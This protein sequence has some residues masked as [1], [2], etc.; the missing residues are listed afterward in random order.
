MNILLI[1]DTKAGHYS[2]GI[3]LASELSR[4]LD[5]SIVEININEIHK[6][7]N[8]EGKCIII[9]VGHAS[10]T[11]MIKIKEILSNTNEC[12]TIAVF[13]PSF[14]QDI[15]DLIVAPEHDFINKRIPNNCFLYK[16][17]LSKISNQ[18][19]D[20]SL[21]AI[22]IGGPNTNIVYD[23]AMVIK[24]IEYVLGIFPEKRKIVSNSRRTPRDLWDDLKNRNQDGQQIKFLDHESI[25]YT[26]YYDATSHAYKKFV[27][28]D[29]INL[30]FESLSAKGETYIMQ[31]NQNKKALKD[32]FYTNK[33]KYVIDNLI[34][35]KNVGSV[36]VNKNKC[37]LI[38]PNKGLKPLQEIKR[39]SLYISNKI[40]NHA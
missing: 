32:Y 13:R 38:D 8:L 27:T 5:I 25:S 10:H 6:I 18:N 1:N 34:N 12:F 22:S 21:I 15:F 17:S 24:S 36:T 30:I 4:Q 31:V 35:S 26:E 9:G 2:Q 11:A 29:S 19:P 14:K 3:A 33:H 23:K 20:T 37:E 16:G 40:Y 7:S 28:P 39:V